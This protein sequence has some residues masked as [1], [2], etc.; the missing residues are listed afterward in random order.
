MPDI[1]VSRPHA[2]SH[3]DALR[4]VEEVASR[5][6]R[7]FGVATRRVGDAVLVEGRGVSGRLQAGPDTLHV[8]A[9]LGLR[10]RPFKRLLRREIESELDR[11]APLS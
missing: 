2:L 7:E 10:A 4:A 11:L 8:E 9:T 1:V 6:H 5:L 3:H